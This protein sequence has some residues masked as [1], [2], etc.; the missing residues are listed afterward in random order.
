MAF[1]HSNQGFIMS[2]KRIRGTMLSL[3]VTLSV[4]IAFGGTV[5][6]DNEAGSYSFSQTSFLITSGGFT[7]FEISFQSLQL[8]SF[9][10]NDN[11]VVQ[12]EYAT[13]VFHN[14]RLSD[15]HG[16]EVQFVAADGYHYYENKRVSV[17][18]FDSPDDKLK[19][20]ILR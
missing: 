13:F 1:F 7:D 8:G 14:G 5:L 10:N 11:E 19:F 12:T 4:L 9:L 16:H 2:K 20:S 3:I 18:S 15:N 6:A 17:G